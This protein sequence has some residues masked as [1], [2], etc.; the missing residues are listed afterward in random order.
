MAAV[1]TLSDMR[2]WI[3]L[4]IIAALL[5]GP[6][7]DF[8]S[9]LV[10]AVLIIQ[11]TLSMDGLSFNAESLKKHRTS[12]IYSLIACFGISTA[13]TLA[14]GYLFIAGHPDIWNGWVLLAATP[15]AVSVVTMSFFFRG[16]TT[17]CVLS[18]A[19]IYIAALALTP[20]ITWA[21]LGESVSVLRIFSYVILFVVVP[22]AASVPL[23]KVK[24]N[25]TARVIA[26]NAMLFTMVFLSLGQNRG[27]L[28]SEPWIIILVAA[29]CVIRIFG[30]SIA[31]LY[32]LKKK[33]VARDKSVVYAP[34]A[35]WKNSGLAVTLCFVLFGSAAEAAVP[36]A[37]S[38]L[39]EVLWFAV[40][41]GYIEKLW[42]G[43]KDVRSTANG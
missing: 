16:N 5:I 26:I 31:M 42:P 9:T 19:V 30:V 38:L 20:L 22:M 32:L 8:S 3:V 6:I 10:V 4:G 27:F 25:R 33:G 7:G 43:G 15:C 12:I 17:M 14:I 13:A 40:I 18:V 11:M 35:V 23:K 41:S 36:C 24:I 2:F 39:I 37:I 29:A 21:I 34:M 1:S 28:F